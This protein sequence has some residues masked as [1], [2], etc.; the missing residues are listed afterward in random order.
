MDEFWQYIKNK[1]SAYEPR[2]Q[3]LH[4]EFEKLL[5][6]LESEDFYN[7]PNTNI[8]KNNLKVLDSQYIM[9]TW[10]KALERKDSDPEGAI[11]SART[12]LESVLKNILIQLDIEFRD[13]MDLN[14]LYKLSPNEQKEQVFKQILVGCSS[15]VTGLSSLR[16]NFGDSHGKAGKVYKPAERHSEFAI[17]L[18]GTMCIF[19]IKTYKFNKKGY[20]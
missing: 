15:I 8:I 6:Y 14:S 12:L 13:D 18:A 7:P 10:S 3:F 17:N 11:T 2:R 5:D 9:D 4:S 19:L 20:N 16:N 1:F